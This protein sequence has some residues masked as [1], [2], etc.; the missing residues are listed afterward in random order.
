MR[1]A[2]AHHALLLLLLT[3]ALATPAGFAHD[4]PA[5]G[6]GAEIRAELDEARREVQL[7]LAAARAELETGNLELGQDLRPGSRGRDEDRPDTL[8][9][10]EITPAGDLLVGGRAVAVDAGQRRELLAYRHQVIDIAIAGIEL[11]ERSANA[12]FDAV[13]QG[14]FRLMFSAM[15]G[16]L[17]RR[18][19][20][21][22]R[23][24]VEPGVRRICLSLPALYDAQQRLAD[25]VP[26]FGP[27]A[28]MQADDVDDCMDEVTREFAQR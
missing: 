8:P 10:A 28:T 23:E 6:I 20:K 5:G 14:L 22:I 1:S 24:S 4:R 17:E 2:L 25:S 26:E 3:T 21:T 12:A 9:R 27:Y 7:D 18:M 13:D 16:S 11:G 19:E 15:T